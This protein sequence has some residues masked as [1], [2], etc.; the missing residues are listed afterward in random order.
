[1]Q[2]ILMAVG[3]VLLGLYFLLPGLAKFGAWDRHIT[4]METHEMSMVHILLAAA[5]ALQIIGG[6]CLILNKQVVVC[7]S[8]FAVMVLLINENLHDFWN[9]YEGLSQAHE[10]QNFVKN[11]AIMAGLLL[12]GSV[13][14]EQPLSLDKRL[15]QQ[16]S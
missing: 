5:G 14:G 4:L 12:L 15:S 7:A 13:Q 16:S 6:L 10:T 3:R 9:V 1:M 11:L 2:R 8:G